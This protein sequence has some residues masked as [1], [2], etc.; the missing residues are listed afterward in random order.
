V[1]TLTGTSYRRGVVCGALLVFIHCGRSRI[2]S[3]IVHT[4]EVTALAGYSL[5]VSL[6][7]KIFFKFQ[8][9][10]FRVPENQSVWC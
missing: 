5:L 2:Y 7:Y 1:P 4:V 6:L 9:F 10:Y 8:Y 3:F